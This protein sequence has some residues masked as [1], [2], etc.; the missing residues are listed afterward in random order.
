MAV[1]SR[2]NGGKALRLAYWNADAVRGR[3]LELEEFLSEH[4]VDI[5]LLNEMHVESGRALRF[6][7]YVCHQ[8]DRPTWGGEA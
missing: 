6:A 7:N 1:R 3:K 8:A 2:T 4:I 5:C